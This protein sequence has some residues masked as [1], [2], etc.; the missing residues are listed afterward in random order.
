MSGRWPWGTG[1]APP[2]DCHECGRRIGERRFHC[3]INNTHV[4]CGKCIDKRHLHATYYPDCPENW[5]DMY[6]HALHFAT[7]AAA[8]YVL[9]ADDPATLRSVT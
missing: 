3:I 1:P 9:T 4:L 7:R 8:W 2:H 6:D 5:H